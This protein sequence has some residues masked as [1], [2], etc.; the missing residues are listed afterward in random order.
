MK[1]QKIY[2]LLS[3]VST[4]FS[5]AS[6]S[7]ALNLAPDGRV[8]LD[9]VFSDND[10]VSAF[11]NTCYDNLPRKGINYY[12]RARGPVVWSDEAWDG[13]DT[14]VGAASSR[15]YAGNVSSLSGMN[16]IVDIG[17][18]SYDYNYWN[19]YWTSIR[20]CTIFLT[21]I[22]TATVKNESDR[23][24]WTAEA[25]LL[26]AYYYSELLKWYGCALPIEKTPYDLAEDFAKTKRSSYYD[27]VKFIMADCDSAL[28][29]S[30]L[31][32]RIIGEAGRV[33]K[34]LAEAIKSKMILFAASPLYNDGK[35]YW[36]EAYLTNKTSLANLEANGY[37][38]YNA[39]HFPAYS[40]KDAYFYPN[41][42]VSTIPSSYAALYNEYFCT[43]MTYTSNPIDQETI[44]QCFYG[45][46][47]Q[48]W[49]NDG[50]GVAAPNKTG[51]CPS[52]E[53]VDSYET[54]DGQP[55]LDLATPYLDA[56][57]TQPNYNP[58]NTL[59]DPANPYLNRDPRFYADIY[60]NGAIRV[61]YWPFAET[62]V[63]KENYNPS[64][65]QTTIASYRP[66]VIATWDGE[67]YTGISQDSRRLTRTGYFERKFLH[68]NAGLKNTTDG[69]AN[70]KLFRLAEVILDF[71]EAAAEDGHLDEARAAVN[72]I[73]ERVRM[74]DI[75]S[76]L[77]KADLI[78]RIRNERRVELA[79]EEN[80]YFDVRRW[81]T[82][83]G[84][85]SNTDQWVTA[86]DIT[87]NLNGTYTYTRR[88][89]IAK[90]RACYTNKYLKVPLGLTEANLMQ[91]LTGE[92]WQNPGW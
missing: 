10:K 71:A 1:I 83:T 72:R 27:V 42:S 22:G 14:S 87:R 2:I 37:A 86:M 5:L 44:Y 28:N 65:K 84:D 78:L 40:A 36:D 9:N 11:L 51:T 58:N 80:R 74:P 53:L 33:N 89:V 70:S 18:G 47:Q 30:E 73:R 19:N 66:R 16:A 68:P 85:L 26:R 88:P 21:R 67:P 82:P 63:C 57:H 39:V 25:H 76:G 12:Y 79:M 61:A 49:V 7:D 20:N 45:N 34:A 8:T 69:G 92:N 3:V 4:V 23:N 54:T 48:I 24:R 75:P 35:N 13:D 32:W 62:P 64:D 91:T 59:Y 38:L 60:Y 77:P 81:T 46:P 41:A 56:Q 29:V 15:L 52:Q 50:F 17:N 55:I 43:T 31:P 6:C 90:P